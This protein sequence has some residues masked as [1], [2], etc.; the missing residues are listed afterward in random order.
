VRRKLVIRGVST[1]LIA[2]LACTVNSVHAQQNDGLSLTLGRIN[3]SSDF[4]RQVFSVKNT[5]S[6]LIRRL[7]VECGFFNNGELIATGRHS[8]ENIEQGTTGFGEVSAICDSRPDRVE[9]RIVFHH[10]EPP[11]SDLLRSTR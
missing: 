10:D 7:E 5:S 2:V 6:T 11:S 3:Y 8:V 4:V 1:I 9:C